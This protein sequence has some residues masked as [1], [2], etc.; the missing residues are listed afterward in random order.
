MSDEI[1]EVPASEPGD[2]REGLV[3]DVVVPIV[4]SGVGGAIGA[5]VTNIMNKP[6]DPPPPP[7]P[8]IELPPGVDRD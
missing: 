3:T 1:R 8:S 6:T 2:V 4:S 5:A 7:P